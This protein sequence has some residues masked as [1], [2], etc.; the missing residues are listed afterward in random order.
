VKKLLSLLPILAL[1]LPLFSFAATVTDNVSLVLPSTSEL[2][3]LDAGSSFDNLDINST[4]FVFT[5]SASE[6]FTLHSSDRR[7]L[8]NDQSASYTCSGS[9]SSLAYTAAGSFTL[10]IT[11]AGTCTASTPA[12]TPT[13]TSSGGGG[14]GNGPI[15]GSIPPIPAAASSTSQSSTPNTNSQKI[16]ALL[17][18]IAKLQAQLAQLTGKSSLSAGTANFTRALKAGAEGNDVKN[19]QIFLNSHGFPLSGTGPG[20]PGNE[21]QIFGAK[22]WAALVRFQ[23]AHAEDI[24]QPL[25]LK[26]GTGIF[27]PSTLKFINGL[28][29]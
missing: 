17:D 20:S 10:T 28:G 13:P 2:Y 25:G 27:G 23:E 6:S 9:E 26:Y 19:L 22:S 1:A 7:N 5:L 8:T 18:T 24:L 14:G 21:T 16:K 11:P 12:P 15:L 4:T 3:T 29:K